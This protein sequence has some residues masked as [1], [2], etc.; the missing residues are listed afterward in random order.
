MT[1]LPMDSPLAPKYWRHEVSGRLDA[2]IMRYVGLLP[3][4]SEDIRLIGLYL[5][6][7]GRFARVGNE[8]CIDTGKTS[9]ARATDYDAQGSRRLDRG[10]GC[11]R[12]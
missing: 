4:T 8:P 7:V 5:A 9:H 12:H 10:G 3:L 1:Q 6:T 11:Y 2:A